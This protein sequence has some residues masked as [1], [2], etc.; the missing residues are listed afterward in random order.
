MT[1]RKSTIGASEFKAKCLGI[2]ERIARTGERVTI[3]K[4]GKPVAEL[5]P[6]SSAD[7]AY[8]QE[9]LRGTVRILG[10][11]IGPVLDPGTWDAESD[12]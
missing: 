9:A 12:S 7:G 11:V 1:H 8:P 4:R 5:G 3:L 10:D 2:L 6:A